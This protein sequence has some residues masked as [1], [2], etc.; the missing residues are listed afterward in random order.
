MVCF[1]H[2]II[3]YLEGAWAKTNNFRIDFVIN[4]LQNHGYSILLKAKN[5][6]SICKGHISKYINF[7]L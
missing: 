4:F 5:L 2:V 3:L 1:L 6:V 7:K